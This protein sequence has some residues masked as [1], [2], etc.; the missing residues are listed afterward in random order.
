LYSIFN[1]P[2]KYAPAQTFLLPEQPNRFTLWCHFSH[3][4]LEFDCGIFKM[5]VAI[6]TKCSI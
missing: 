4:I 6:I 5:L 2:A 1:F 3:V